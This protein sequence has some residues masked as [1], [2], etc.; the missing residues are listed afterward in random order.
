MQDKVASLHWCLP[1]PGSRG[2]FRISQLTADSTQVSVFRP[3][4]ITSSHVSI[5]HHR[6]SDSDPWRF[7]LN[8]VVTCDQAVTSVVRVQNLAHRKVLSCIGQMKARLKLVHWK[9]SYSREQMEVGSTGRHLAAPMPGRKASF[10]VV[11]VTSLLRFTLSS[12]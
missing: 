8:R 1:T 5:Q 10:L 9:E 4:Y 7:P 3:I 12:S 2:H 11:L 6:N